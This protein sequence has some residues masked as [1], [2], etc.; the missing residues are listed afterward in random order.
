MKTRFILV[1][2]GESE[3]NL[4]NRFAGQIDVSLT[5]TGRKQAQ[6]TGEFLKNEKIR[7]F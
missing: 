3:G 5:K 7:V 1:R 6:C 2:H 4:T